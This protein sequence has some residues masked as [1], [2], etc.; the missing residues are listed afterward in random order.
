MQSSSKVIF[1]QVNSL[2]SEEHYT[3]AVPCIEVALVESNRLAE[4]ANG[5]LVTLIREMLMTTKG[6]C[7]HEGGVDLQSSL[8]EPNRSEVL[9]L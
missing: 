9:P 4:G 8:K 3:Q 7:V 5:L 1:R 6:M 2:L